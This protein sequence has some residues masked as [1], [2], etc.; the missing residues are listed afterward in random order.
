[1]CSSVSDDRMTTGHLFMCLC[2]LFCAIL[3]YSLILLQAVPEVFL[4]QLQ[5]PIVTL[6]NSACLCSSIYVFIR[7]RLTIKMQRDRGVIVS[8]PL[9]PLFQSHFS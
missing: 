2:F 8:L 4:T 1:M 6:G 5:T 7:V 3:A 9:H